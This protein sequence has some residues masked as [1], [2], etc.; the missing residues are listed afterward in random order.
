MEDEGIEDEYEYYTE[1]GNGEAESAVID[2]IISDWKGSN[3]DN[4][5]N[6]DII[7]GIS[8]K[9]AEEYNLRTGF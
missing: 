1:Y 9:I 6:F 4:F 3:K 7:V 8:E 5:T 2:Q